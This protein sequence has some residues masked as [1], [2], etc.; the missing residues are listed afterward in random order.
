MGGPAGL[1]M[2]MVT[3]TVFAGSVT[4]IVFVSVL[5]ASVSCDII[6]DK[7]TFVVGVCV[8]A[9]AVVVV[10]F[11]CVRMIVDCPVETP[12][13]EVAAEPELPSTATTEYEAR[14]TVGGDDLG[15]KGRVWESA[16]NERSRR[17]DGS[18]ERISQMHNGKRMDSG[19]DCYFKVDR[20][21][22]ADG[23]AARQGP[24]SCKMLVEQ[25][26]GNYSK[27]RRDEEVSY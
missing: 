12:D 5:G 10:V 9:E 15:C 3:S 13:D 18:I 19:D 24:G 20:E 11:S 7:T 6:V 21:A 17:A 2:L 16:E 1:T 23:F 14:L 26:L 8:V 27:E 25:S 22:Q 4:S